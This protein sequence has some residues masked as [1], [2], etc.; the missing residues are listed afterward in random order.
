MIKGDKIK[1]VKPMGAFTNVGEICEVVDVAEGGVISF[2]FGG[3][4]HL[5]CMSYDEFQKY[6]EAVDVPEKKAPKKPVR[7]WTGWYMLHVYYHNING[8]YVMCQTYYRHNGKRVQVRS[9]GWGVRA[10]AACHRDDEFDVSVGQKLAVKR[11]VLKI[12]EKQVK[13]YAEGL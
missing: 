4:R 5:G 3:G 12:L 8:D 7:K 1:L 2:K 6:F 10:E 13:E 11:L 9:D